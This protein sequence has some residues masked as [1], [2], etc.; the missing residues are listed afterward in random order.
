MVESAMRTGRVRG[1]LVGE[2]VVEGVIVGLEE[3][4]ANVPAKL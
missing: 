3:G 4:M 1:V 2:I